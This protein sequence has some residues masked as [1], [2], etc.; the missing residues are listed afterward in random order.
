[1]KFQ[2]HFLEPLSPGLYTFQPPV[3]LQILIFKNSCIIFF[4]Q[5][6]KIYRMLYMVIQ[7]VNVKFLVVWDQVT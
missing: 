5:G 7:F 6:Q 2:R 3:T 1:M 4:V